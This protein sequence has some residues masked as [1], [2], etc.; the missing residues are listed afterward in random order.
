MARPW[1][2]ARAEF[3]CP[4]IVSPSGRAKTTS[5]TLRDSLPWK[6]GSPRHVPHERNP[7][8][9]RTVNA[10]K[11]DGCRFR[12]V[13]LFVHAVSQPPSKVTVHPHVPPP[14]TTAIAP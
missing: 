8:I 12:H 3:T 1:P 7:L 11:S 6:R 13:T 10:V 2:H 5:Y 9:P 4:V 14:H